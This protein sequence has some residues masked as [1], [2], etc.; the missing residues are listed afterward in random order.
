MID[1][2][3]LDD[4]IRMTMTPTE[5]KVMAYAKELRA[6]LAIEQEKSAALAVRVG[7]MRKVLEDSLPI[8]WGS[9]G[10]AYSKSA[11]SKQGDRADKVLRLPDN[12]SEVLRDRD[13]E[14]K[15]ERDNYK[16]ALGDIKQAEREERKKK[17][18]RP[19]GTEG[20]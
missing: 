2:E 3:T 9:C 13:A 5:K 14:T 20:R 8:L 4:L 15:L 6:A 1:D 19:K 7:E 17:K 16:R 18:G 10:E 11:R 12:A